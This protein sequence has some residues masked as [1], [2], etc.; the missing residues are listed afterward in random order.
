MGPAA[1]THPRSVPPGQGLR[2]LPVKAHVEAVEARTGVQRR[3]L[4]G[5]FSSYL[6]FME[7]ER[8]GS[9]LERQA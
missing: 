3:A 5:G 2:V 8:V 7:W 4:G 1:R 9:A 6:S